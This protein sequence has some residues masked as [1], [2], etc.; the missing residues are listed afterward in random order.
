MESKINYLKFS[1]DEHRSFS[2]F[3][4]DKFMW[5]YLKHLKTG[6]YLD[7]GS[8]HPINGNNTY[9]FYLNG[10]NGICIDPLLDENLYLQYR[11]KDLSIKKFY[12]NKKMETFYR[13][14][15]LDQ[16]S[17]YK[18]NPFFKDF[19]YKIEIVKFIDF[20]TLKQLIKKHINLLSI[21]CEGLDLQ[22]I[23]N[24]INLYP[25]IVCLEVGEE[26]LKKLDEL[27]TLYEYKRHYY[28]LYNAIYI[29]TSYEKM[30]NPFYT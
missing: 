26:S 20:I 1:C 27:M 2:Q 15:E 17:G 7:L 6:Y 14:L 11:P 3:G 10:W 24:L 4:E 16:I 23:K 21:D 8:S 13:C 9:L 18:I 30:I 5:G 12:I 29:K 25:D 22:I 19:N 28:N